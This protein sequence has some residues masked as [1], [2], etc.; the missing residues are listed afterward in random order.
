MTAGHPWAFFLLNLLCWMS[1]LKKWPKNWGGENKSPATVLTFKH[2]ES[3][4]HSDSWHWGALSDDMSFM[5]IKSIMS[6]LEVKRSPNFPFFEILRYFFLAPCQSHE[7]ALMMHFTLQ[8]IQIDILL[9]FYTTH[10][11]ICWKLTKL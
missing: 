6:S 9:I 10:V 5:Q 3:C 8:F 4:D 7:E 11:Q 1:H 2:N